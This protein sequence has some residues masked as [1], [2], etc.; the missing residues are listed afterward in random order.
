MFAGFHSGSR[1]DRAITFFSVFGFSVPSFWI[2][3]ILILIF[4]V[5]FGLLPSFGRG[6]T[7][8]FLGI[9]SSV[10]SLDGWQHVLLPALN[11][12]IFPMALLM[13]L[14]RAGTAEAVRL[15]F[16]RFARAKGVRQHRLVFVHIL[17]Y[18]SIRSEER[19]VGKE[20]VC[21]CSFWWSPYHSKKK[22]KQTHSI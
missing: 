16:V 22:N 11:L 7:A 15:D 1:W 13:R 5:E 18:I 17:K 8:T 12:S 20:C 14:A 6:E 3:I 4:S 9:E 2:G 10:W 21:T 19:R